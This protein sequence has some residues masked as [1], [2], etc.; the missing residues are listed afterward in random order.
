MCSSFPT[1]MRSYNYISSLSIYS[2]KESA[3]WISLMKNTRENGQTVRE[4][5]PSHSMSFLRYR[6][7]TPVYSEQVV[8]HILSLIYIHGGIIYITRLIYYNSFSILI[9]KCEQLFEL[10]EGQGRW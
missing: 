6:P 4:R 5:N 3:E 8:A 7:S 1:D 2:G 10:R 9:A